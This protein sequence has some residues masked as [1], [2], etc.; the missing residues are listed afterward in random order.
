MEIMALKTNV[1]NCYATRVEKYMVTL[2]A[3]GTGT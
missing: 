3:S 1:A 2:E